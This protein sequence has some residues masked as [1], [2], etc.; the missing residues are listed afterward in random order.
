MKPKLHSYGKNTPTLTG[1]KR[2]L[3][4]MQYEQGIGYF[5]PVSI[6][7]SAFKKT[8]EIWESKLRASGFHDIETR[9]ANQTGRVS[10]FFAQNGSSASFES[11]YDPSREHYYELARQF[12]QLFIDKS[13]AMARDVREKYPQFVFQNIFKRKT[14]L[15]AYL[16]Y[17]HMNGVTY[18]MAKLFLN[19]KR[20]KVNIHWKDVE[21]PSYSIRQERSTYWHHTHGQKA[22]LVFYAWLKEAHNI[23]ARNTHE[24][25]WRSQLSGRKCKAG[26]SGKRKAG[27]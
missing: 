18:R 17:L 19:G 26:N 24:R 27:P 4:E 22:L 10:T 5:R 3:N 15:Y 11:V 20:P 23:D 9:N 16:F 13:N 21:L 6:S 14:S 2:K 25:E 8:Y 7:P 1:R 12:Y